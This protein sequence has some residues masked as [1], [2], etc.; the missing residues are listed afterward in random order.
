M[1]DDRLSRI[2]EDEAK[3]AEHTRK[4]LVFWAVRWAIAGTGAVAIVV[5]TGDHHWLLPAAAAIAGVS[6]GVIL[7]GAS[8]NRKRLARARAEAEGR[9]HD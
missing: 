4:S 1:A 8:G 2:R 3:L 9:A 6:L 5:F 7:V